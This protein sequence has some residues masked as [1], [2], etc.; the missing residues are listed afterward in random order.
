VD[1]SLQN[2]DYTFNGGVTVDEVG[3]DPSPDSATVTITRA[4]GTAVVTGATAVN[5]PNGVFSYTLVPAQTALLDTLTAT[6]SF[7][8]NGRLQ[9]LRD[10]VEIVGGYH[11]DLNELRQMPPLADKNAYST[12]KLLNARTLA[13]TTIE[14]ACGRAFVPRY[15]IERVDSFQSWPFPDVR[16]LRSAV[17][18]DGTILTGAALTDAFNGWYPYH[19]Y[20]Y[21]NRS[22]TVG[23][24]YGMDSCPAD[25]ARASM[26]LARSYLIAGSAAGTGGLEERATT[27]SYADA[28]LTYGLVTAGARGAVTSIPEVNVT[29]ER[30]K[31][32]AFA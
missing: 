4:D 12:A 24:E 21:C 7:T 5:G 23:V 18:M 17:N 8:L 20:R 19:S 28:G 30:Y 15:S 1:R 27:V 9:S 3:T 13:E 6:W 2:T 14:Q 25:V 16:A 10:Q 26:L 32:V 29:I 22:W 11:F 31:M